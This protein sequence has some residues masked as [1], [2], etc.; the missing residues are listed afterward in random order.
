MP[1]GDE[2]SKFGVYLQVTRK[3][4]SLVDIDNEVDGAIKRLAVT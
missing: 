4:A 3:E 2:E 1:T